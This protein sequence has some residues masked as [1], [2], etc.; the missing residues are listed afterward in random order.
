MNNTFTSEQI[1]ETGDL[2]ADLVMRQYM[3]DKLAKYMEIKSTNPKL[4]QSELAKELN[5]SSS[6]LQR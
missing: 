2:T 4:K 5:V 6:T 1:A 3:L